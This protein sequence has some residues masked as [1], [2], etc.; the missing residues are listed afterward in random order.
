[1]EAPCKRRRGDD[2]EDAGDRDR[3][4]ALPDSLLREVMSHMKARQVV[5]T[6]V[7]ARRFEDFMDT[8]LCP[9]NVSIALLD[10]LRLHASSMGEDRRASRW[11]RRGIKYPHA[12]QEPGLQRGAPSCS[13]W[14]LRRLHLSNLYLCN[15]L[16]EHVRSRCPSLEDLELESC[17][18]EF[19]AIASRSL[20]NLVLKRC[21]LKGFREITDCLF[22]ITAPAVTSMFLGVSPYN[23]TGGLSLSEMPSLA[24]A[25]V[26]E[27]G[28]ST[29]TQFNN[30]RALV[31]KSSD[32][33]DDF[34]ILGHFLRNSP[35]LERLTLRCFKYSNDTKKKKGSSKLKKAEPTPHPNLVDVPCKN[36]KLTEIIYKEDDIRHLIE[37]FLRIS[38]NLPNNCIKLTKVV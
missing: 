16:A 34:Q 26:V 18:C 3:L 14:R 13:S 7:L 22:V 27:E 28:S 4:N 25:T 36:L 24:K 6:C 15:L 35:N 8:L 30:L 20:K 38:G 32:L 31:L 19:P 10:T 17:T 37:L 33:S 29:F 5:Q 12:G 1:M 23:F 2:D 21:A 9:G 11:I